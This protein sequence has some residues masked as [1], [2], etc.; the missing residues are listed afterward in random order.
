MERLDVDLIAP[1][2][3]AGDPYPTYAWMRANE[4]VYTI[5]TNCG[6]SP[7]T[8]TSSESRRT[9]RPSSTQI[10]KKAGIGQMPAD[11]AIVGLDD[12]AH[13]K[14]RQLVSRRFT[15]RAVSA[16]EGNVRDRVT[17]ILDEAQVTNRSVEI[18]SQM[19]APL[20]TMM[21]GM[22]LGFDEAEWPR[23]THWAEA[24]NT[25]GGGPQY[26]N[27]KGIA[28]A[29]VFAGVRLDLFNPE[30]ASPGEDILSHYATAE[31]DGCPMGEEEC[32]PIHCCAG[33]RRRDNPHRDRPHDR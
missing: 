32:W 9:R 24:T 3:Y 21:I 7:A 8:T 5:S 11:R 31:I 26:M 30:K 1:A 6:V 17:R 15:P 18:V 12:P 29:M 2:L 4:P 27:D 13:S 22:P 19:A 28:A 25:L 33:R 16:W 23:L 20:P 10:P 14:R